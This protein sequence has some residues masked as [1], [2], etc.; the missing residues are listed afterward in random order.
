MRGISVRLVTRL[1]Q[2]DV[3]MRESFFARRGSTALTSGPS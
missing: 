3:L 1:L 2:K